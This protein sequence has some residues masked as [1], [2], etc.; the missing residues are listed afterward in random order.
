[1]K[2]QKSKAS[3]E[4]HRALTESYLRSFI[5]AY[6]DTAKKYGESESLDKIFTLEILSFFHAISGLSKKK[7]KRS[8]P[9][10]N[11]RQKSSWG[12]N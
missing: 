12:W 6:S 2:S 10:N 5:K 8:C 4:K 11:R 3:L 9:N 7:T 1:M